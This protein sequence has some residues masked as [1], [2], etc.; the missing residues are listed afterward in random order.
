MATFGVSI[1]KEIEWRG[2]MQE[3]SNVYHYNT[4]VAENFTDEA[5]IAELVRLEKTIHS[6]NVDFKIGRTWGPTHTGQ[7]N[8]VMRQIVDLDG[9]GA[10][11]PA[12]NF[13]RELAVLIIWPLGRYGTRN[14]PQFLR[15]WLHLDRNI[16]YDTS[17][18]TPLAVA[19]V[20]SIVDYIE[21]VTVLDP[22]I[23]PGQV[24]LSTWEGREPTGPGRVYEYLEHR[25]LG[26]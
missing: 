6:T 22:S 21:G 1:T 15:K 14:R 16:G 26:R 7:E 4:D 5:V 24:E 8:S 13:Y 2:G 19:P 11:S 20:Q 10:V 18:S 23:F 12:T 9:S 25:Q 3:F 17:G